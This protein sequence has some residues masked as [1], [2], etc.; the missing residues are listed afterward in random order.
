MS[1]TLTFDFLP[2]PSSSTTTNSSNIPSYTFPPARIELEAE[3]EVYVV[4]FRPSGSSDPSSSTF[5]ASGD[6]DASS[7]SGGGDLGDFSDGNNRLCILPADSSDAK[8]L[9]EVFAA[10]WLAPGYKVRCHLTLSLPP[11]FKRV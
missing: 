10:I 4:G 5:S 6:D 1:P 11:S 9:K 8:R 7:Y 3:N 2:S